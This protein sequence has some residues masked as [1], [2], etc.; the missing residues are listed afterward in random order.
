VRAPRAAQNPRRARHDDRARHNSAGS[1][2]AGE[3][4]PRAAQNPRRALSGG[5]PYTGHCAQR[6]L[7][8][9]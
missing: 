6:A 5:H 4:E 7:L 3:R 8:L 2:T 1:I 9:K